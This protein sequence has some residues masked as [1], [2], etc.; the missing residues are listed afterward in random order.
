M[1]LP[2]CVPNC[3]KP[4]G[5]LT[6]DTTSCNWAKYGVLWFLLPAYL[7]IPEV[8]DGEMGGLSVFYCLCAILARTLF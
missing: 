4:V 8:R 6:Y 1:G 3:G 5:N 2:Q 7:F